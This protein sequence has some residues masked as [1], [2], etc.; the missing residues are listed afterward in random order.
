MKDL[1]AY[2]KIVRDAKSDSIEFT[3]WP[4]DILKGV[5]L[6]FGDSSF[7]NVGKNRTSSQAGL[8]IMY[9]ADREALLRGES[10]RIASHL[11]VAPNQ[12]RGTKHSCS[13]NDGSAG[14][15]RTCRRHEGT[16]RRA[17]RRN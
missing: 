8:I 14:G 3:F 16:L 13:G 11:E 7:A 1:L 12:T 6:A 15:C 2:N 10:S 4:M 17:L 9:A 5:L